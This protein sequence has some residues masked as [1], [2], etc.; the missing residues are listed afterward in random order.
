MSNTWPF[1]HNGKNGELRAF[2]P[3]EKISSWQNDV[4]SLV[5]KCRILALLF[6][7]QVSSVECLTRW[8]TEFVLTAA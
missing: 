7:P 4:Q 2:K 6:F 8:G 5:K 1:F 3:E